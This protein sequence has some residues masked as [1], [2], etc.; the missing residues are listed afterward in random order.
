MTASV[1]AL[2]LIQLDVKQSMQIVLRRNID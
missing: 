2:L 1:G